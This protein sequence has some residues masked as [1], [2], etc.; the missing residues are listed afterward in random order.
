MQDSFNQNLN[1]DINVILNPEILKF[2]QQALPLSNKEHLSNLFPSTSF[3]KA[4][5]IEDIEINS[6]IDLSNNEFNF[7]N[8]IGKDQL[9]FLIR[10]GYLYPYELEDQTPQKTPQTRYAFTK[11]MY[12]HLKDWAQELPNNRKTEPANENAVSDPE[13]NLAL[14]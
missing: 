5:K 3:A 10:D 7:S 14:A 13:E 6:M 11:K 4:K 12:D 9:N 1:T 8:L 2:F